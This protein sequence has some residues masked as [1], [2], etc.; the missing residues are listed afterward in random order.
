ML[1]HDN[2]EEFQDPANYDLEEAQNS[3]ANGRFYA[4]LAERVGGPVLELA[5]GTGLVAIP[6]A[7]RGLAVT[8]VDASRPMLE[9]AELKTGD[10]G[11]HWILADVRK[12][13]L[14][15]CFDLVYLTGNAFQAFLSDAD[16]SA[17]LAVIRKHLSPDG[18][19]ACE[20]RNP[21]AYDLNAVQDEERWFDYLNTEGCRVQVSG[22]QQFDE[23][24]RVMHW[25][26][27]RR[28][29]QSGCERE[30]VTRIACRF[31]SLEEL[32]ELLSTHGFS[33]EACY[34]D[35]DCTPLQ[36]ESEQFVLVCR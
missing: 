4:D 5:C 27:Y 24:A 25:T 30:C 18:V 36:P 12:L 21:S 23:Q 7:Q 2:L 22:V 26:T 10:A 28:W 13:D 3:I 32:T 20:T 9:H 8:G 15:E 31:S 1:E 14:D 19:F 33:I 17:L 11:C 29:T 16:Q 35:F 6:V 34:G